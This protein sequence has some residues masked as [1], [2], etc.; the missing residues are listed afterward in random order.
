MDTYNKSGGYN[1]GFDCI[2]NLKYTSLMFSHNVFC[3]SEFSMLI[4]NPHAK[5]LI[6]KILLPCW[7]TQLIPSPPTSAF[8]GQATFISEYQFN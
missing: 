3:L 4:F 8:C 7:P 5:I 1:W 6:C 2:Y